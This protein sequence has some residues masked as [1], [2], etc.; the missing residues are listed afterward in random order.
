MHQTL[1]K[2]GLAPQAEAF[3][4]KGKEVFPLATYW[5]SSE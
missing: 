4:V 5:T 1:V 3:K 2:A